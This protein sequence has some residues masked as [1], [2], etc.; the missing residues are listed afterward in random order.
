MLYKK[1]LNGDVRAAAK[2]IRDID[3]KIPSAVEE[4]KKLYLHSGNAF[5]IGVTGS[6]GV[7]KSTLIDCLINEF[8]KKDRSVGIIAIDPTSPFSKGAILGDRIRMNRHTLDEKVFIRSLATRGHLGGL[9][10]STNDIVTVMDAMGKDVILIETV[11]VGQDEIEI[12]EIAHTVIVTLVPG[13]GDEIQ[14]I[15][16]G[17]LEIGD[18]YIINKSERDGAD[19]LF[20]ELEGMI[21]MNNKGKDGWKPLIFKTEAIKYKGIDEVIDGIE[22]H[23]DYLIRN[24]LFKRSDRV[25]EIFLE[26]LREK[27]MGNLLK[28]IG[29]NLDSMVDDIVERRTDP[30]TIAER[31]LSNYKRE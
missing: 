16:A 9:S 30:Y 21:E 29:E 3:D 27:I 28:D 19:R 1:I 13:M 24:S 20:R 8:R 12:V 31:V 25:R 5:I 18:I 22:L 17:I 23:R 10:A 14:I 7:G 26:I 11:G 15:K 2:L 4:L 6:P